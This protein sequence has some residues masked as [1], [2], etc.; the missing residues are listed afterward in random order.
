MYCIGYI[1]DDECGGKLLL[2]PG[3]RGVRCIGRGITYGVTEVPLYYEHSPLY[4]YSLRFNSHLKSMD[5]NPGMQ[6]L[7]LK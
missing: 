1:I 4:L 3:F 7:V 5:V 2:V 6:L